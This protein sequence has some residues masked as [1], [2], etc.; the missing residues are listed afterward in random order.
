[1]PRRKSKPDAFVD[2]TTLPVA[3]VKSTRTNPAF[4]HEC[5]ID[6]IIPVS[7]KHVSVLAQAIRSVEL[8]TIPYP[9]WRII[10]VNDTG[11]NID[12][13]IPRD[14]IYVINNTGKHG[15]SYARNLAL[16]EARAP[17]VL[18]LDADDWLINTTLELYLKAYT[19]FDTG[20][21][22]GDAIIV[23][24]NGE[25]MYHPPAEQA[26]EFPQYSREFYLKA[27]QHQVTALIPTSLARDV[28]FDES[29]NIW[30]DYDFYMHMAAKGYC[31]T[32][33]LYP[34]IVYNWD[35]GTN[36]ETGHYLDSVRDNGRA[37][38]LTA[39]V[40]EKW[41]ADIE[42]PRMAC[43]GSG[44]SEAE[45]AREALLRTTNPNIA[46]DVPMEWMGR[47][48]GPITYR[49]SNGTGRAYAVGNLPPHR[50]FA[51][52]PRDVAWMTSLGARE[53]PKPST[54]LIIPNAIQFV[55][56]MASG[57]TGASATA[58]GNENTVVV[59]PTSDEEFK[60]L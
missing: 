37:G 17:F 44:K 26:N 29:I 59:P 2:P 46:G 3:D 5:V 10:V 50:F 36:R 25:K 43:C 30:E 8:Q 57:G 15:S 32:R 49:S 39:R 6:I 14:D 1:M 60:E 34:V 9:Y 41:R 24:A 20:Y 23:K 31:G 48:S 55:T 12:A 54:P 40:R 28:R 16:S 19:L 4:N 22:Y 13:S 33:I 18:F 45:R 35:A 27:N 56:P 53:Q 21:V 51:C 38:D 58:S 7:S 11:R 42:R 52:D 47:N